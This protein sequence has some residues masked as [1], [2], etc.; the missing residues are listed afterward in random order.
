MT[1]NFLQKLLKPLGKNKKSAQNKKDDKYFVRV[2]TVRQKE[3][4]L[5]D[6]DFLGSVKPSLPKKRALSSD[7]AVKTVDVQ[8]KQR[9]K[10]KEKKQMNI[11]SIMISEK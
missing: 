10:T 6:D 4:K 3:F 8:I 9:K 1:K 7:I 2:K 11:V 5:K